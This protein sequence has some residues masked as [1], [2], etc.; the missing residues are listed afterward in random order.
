MA[1]RD[2]LY[3]EGK[4]Y[5]EKVKGATETVLKEY[6]AEHAFLFYG[7]EEEERA[8]EDLFYYLKKEVK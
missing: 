7:G 4:E 6:P 8:L 3:S 5:Y 2:Y 1:F